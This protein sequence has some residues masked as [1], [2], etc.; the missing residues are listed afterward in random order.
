MRKLDEVVGELAA[1]QKALLER[2]VLVA[3]DTD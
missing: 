1:K 2:G 3:S